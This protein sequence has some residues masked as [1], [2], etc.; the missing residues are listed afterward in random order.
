MHAMP[1]GT[2]AKAELPE[3][4]EL[5]EQWTGVPNMSPSVD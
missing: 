5:D 3:L 4:M 2:Q 1:I